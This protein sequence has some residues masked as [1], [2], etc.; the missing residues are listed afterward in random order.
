MDRRSFLAACTVI[1]VM[2]GYDP[3]MANTVR[4]SMNH[5]PD[6]HYRV[7]RE[8]S[9]CFFYAEKRK[10]WILFQ[11]GMSTYETKEVPDYLLSFDRESIDPTGLLAEFN[12][13]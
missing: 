6:R 13:T 12:R 8:N 4:F 1:V 11:R 7:D 5:N 10:S 9:M 3:I 2:P